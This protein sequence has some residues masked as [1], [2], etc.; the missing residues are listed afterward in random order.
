MPC[1]N[2]PEVVDGL[3]TCA[4]CGRSF[5]QD[6]VI[7]LQGQTV[8]A[9]CKRERVQ[10]IKSGSAQEDLELGGRGGR[11]VG[12][13]VDNLVINIPLNFIL[14][15]VFVG[16]G[17]FAPHRG[18][19]LQLG[20][21][22]FL[23]LIQLLGFLVYEGLMLTARGQTLGKMAAKLKV[24]SADGGDLTAGQAW[25]RAGARILLAITGIGGLIDVLMIFGKDRLTLH[26]RIAKTRVVSWR[27]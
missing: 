12:M 22:L 17:A 2:H 21:V 7:S 11:F 26:D 6:C 5:C 1:V 10:D 15:L 16:S 9:A 4:R 27:R 18:D 24:V 14:P 8:C 25:L 23:N 19:A 20:M 13:F 3:S